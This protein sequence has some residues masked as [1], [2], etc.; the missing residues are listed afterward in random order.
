M[1]INLSIL[2]IIRKVYKSLNYKHA[3]AALELKAEACW[4]HSVQLFELLASNT[5]KVLTRNA[6]LVVWK[7]RAHKK[8]CANSVRKAQLR[9]STSGITAKI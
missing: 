9:S 6:M 7:E 3:R 2:G 8:L 4:G 1:Q 5:Y